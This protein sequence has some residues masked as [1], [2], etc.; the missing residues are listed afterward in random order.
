M[1]SPI[2]H[3]EIPLIFTKK[4]DVSYDRLRASRG[5]VDF[6][7]E[8]NRTRR[9]RHALLLAVSGDDAHSA[10]RVRLLKRL[11]SCVNTHEHELKG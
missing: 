11:L 7:E 8:I 4:L 1:I 2:P 5:K 10:L 9:L 3:C 6:Q